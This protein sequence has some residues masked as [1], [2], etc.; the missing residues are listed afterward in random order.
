MI[1]ALLSFA[2]ELVTKAGYPG[3]VFVAALENF[4]PPLP[5]EVIFPFVGFIAGKGVLSLLLV[6]IAGVSG[7]FIGAL[8]WYAAGYLLGATDLKFLIAR[9]GKPL[10]I[11]LEDVEKAEDWFAKYKTQ[12][13]FFGRLIPLV[14]TFISIPAGF[15]KMNLFSFSFLTIAG[16]AIW[17][18]G[19]TFAGSLLGERWETVVPYLENYEIGVTIVIAV[20]VLLFL[21]RKLT[22]THH[23]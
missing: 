4:F 20:L 21:V 9:Y 22:Q 2:Q 6:T 3:I 7:A 12:V 1:D 11:K 8:F 15:V 10:G 5:S 23:V 14:R 18:G 16:S 13:I 19:L 17:I